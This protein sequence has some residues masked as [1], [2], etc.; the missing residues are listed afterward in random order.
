MPKQTL[1]LAMT[2][3]P[4]GSDPE[5]AMRSSSGLTLPMAKASS[6]RVSFGNQATFQSTRQSLGS[7]KGQPRRVGWA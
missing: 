3:L 2:N 4:L 6:S 7:G 1:Q 5:V